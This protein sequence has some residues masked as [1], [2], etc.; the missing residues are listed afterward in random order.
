MEEPL[1]LGRVPDP[2]P[3]ER[4]AQDGRNV[5]DPAGQ[6]AGTLRTAEEAR[7]F[8]AAVNA[9]SGMPTDALEAWTTG[10]INDPVHQLAAE[11]EALIEFGPHPDERRR[12]ERR[13]GDR[14][15]LATLVRP[16]A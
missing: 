15:R 3:E 5:L 4:W 14:R 11:L 1:T 12:G 13:Q 9:V 6:V 7:R 2:I 8:V 10:V 16:R